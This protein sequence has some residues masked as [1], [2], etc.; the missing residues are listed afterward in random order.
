[1]YQVVYSVGCQSSQ[2]FKLVPFPPAAAKTHD[3]TPSQHKDRGIDSG[4]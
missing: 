3:S 4:R 1:M 2:A